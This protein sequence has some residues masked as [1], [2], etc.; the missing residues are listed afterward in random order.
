MTA[1]E[2][3][4]PRLPDDVIV[5]RSPRMRAVFEYIAHVG[6]SHSTVLVTGESGTGKEVVAR[7]I[8]ARSPRRHAPFVAVSCALFADSLIE[9][10]LFGHER[11]AFTGAVAARPGRFERA[12]GGTLFLDDIDDVPLGMQVKLLRVLQNRCIERLG[13]TRTIPVDVRVVAG[14]KRDLRRMVAEG[15]FREDLYYRL[16]V[17]AVDLPPLRERLEDLPELARHFLTRFFGRRG[18]DCPPISDAVMQAFLAYDWPGNVR[19]LE[20]ACE[21][22]AESAHCGRVG[23]GCVAA[24][25]LFHRPLADGDRVA[26]AAAGRVENTGPILTPVREPEGAAP[27]WQGGQF[28]LDDY[29]RDVEA[30]LITQA[31]EE[32]AG[33][34]S[35]AARLLGI[36]RSTLGDRI[37]RCRKAPSVALGGQAADDEQHAGRGD[38]ERQGGGQSLPPA[39]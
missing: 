5:G 20:N 12:E 2:R 13:G 27:P 28:A 10:E 3:A 32:S 33:N 21:R 22:M 35:Q 15:A 19:E 29:L 26:S 25:V 14:S 38:G 30:A 17:I 23:I 18:L 31:L 37:M 4:A 39:S 7:A 16:N 8:H 1:A 9:S 11:G 34:K 6:A 24:S 36:K